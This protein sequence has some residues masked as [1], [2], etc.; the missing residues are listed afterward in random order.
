M[1][2][3]LFLA[4]AAVPAMGAIINQELLV[5]TIDSNYSGI[6]SYSLVVS[7]KDS[8]LSLRIWHHNSQWRQEWVKT[9]EQGQEVVAVAVGQGQTTL[10][11]LGNPLIGP[12]LTAILFHKSSWW[13]NAGLDFQ[14]Q[15]YHFF[16]G[17][18]ALALGMV[19]AGDPRPNLWLDNEQMVPLRMFFSKKGKRV[20][21]GWLEHRNIGNYKLPH[22]AL[23]STEQEQ[24]ICYLDWRD[25]N[26]HYDT[27]LFSVEALKQS[28]SG[29][30]LS[31]P[32]EVMDFHQILAGLK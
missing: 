10:K 8:D 7:L 28:F 30:S 23:L 25:I 26:A 17:R 29:V 1:F 31:P 13:L 4:A 21:L 18:P 3:T 2:L 24:M 16:H 6:S 19:L 14:V 9:S 20:D 12:P 32:D 15:S 5:K 27:R 22:K 11:S